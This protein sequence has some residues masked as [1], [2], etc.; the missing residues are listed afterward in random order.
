LI[1][2]IIRDGFLPFDEFFGHE[3]FDEILRQEGVNNEEADNRRREEQKGLFGF[4]HYHG[5]HETQSDK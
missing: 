5:Q 3:T 2:L 1:R 4:G